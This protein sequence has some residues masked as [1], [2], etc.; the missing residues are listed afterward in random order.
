MSERKDSARKHQK[1]TSKTDLSLDD[2]KLNTAIRES[3]TPNQFNSMV[4]K[5]AISVGTQQKP[6]K[7]DANT[8]IKH[9]A[10]SGVSQA[11]AEKPVQQLTLASVKIPNTVH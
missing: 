6:E 7:I 2:R 1:N 11:E 10:S 4:N 9:P 3:K 5:D 8:V